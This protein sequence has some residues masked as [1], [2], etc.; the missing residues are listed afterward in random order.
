MPSR[1]ELHRLLATERAVFASVRPRCQAL[2]EDARRHLLMGVPMPWMAKWAG[3]A[4]VFLDRGAR[5][6]A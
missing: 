2:A 6:R 3:G 5:A 1:D 4:P